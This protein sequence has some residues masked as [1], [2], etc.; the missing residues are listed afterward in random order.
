VAWKLKMKIVI[1]I[2]SALIFL[3]LAACGISSSSQVFIDLTAK[4][5]S[6]S[7]S[8][9]EAL[10]SFQEGNFS[11]AR[12]QALVAKVQLY[13]FQSRFPSF[14]EKYE[15]NYLRT[16]TYALLASTE[17]DNSRRDTFRKV[18]EKHFAAL[19]PRFKEL[20]EPESFLKQVLRF[21]AEKRTGGPKERGQAE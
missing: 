13:E 5:T 10:Y 4:Y 7:T 21:K 20:I 16:L 14:I 15:I 11:N 8:I 12:D 2:I 17:P 19:L 18:Y 1:S 9:D 6:I 3:C